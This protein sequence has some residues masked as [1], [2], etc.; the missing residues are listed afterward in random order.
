MDF[1]ASDQVKETIAK[2]GLKIDDVMDVVKTAEG[3][4]KKITNKD[5]KIIAKKV[6]NNVTVYADYNIEKGILKSHAN[7][8]S[9]YSHRMTLGK[10]V[11]ATEPS[12]WT[13]LHCNQQAFLGTAEMSYIGVSRNGPAVVCTKCGDVW[14]E[15]YLATKTLAAAEGLFE[16]KKA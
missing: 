13:C 14:V 8:N 4:N 9:A 5:G 12:P 1:K 11:N 2:R 6:I 3:A 15:E 16:K 7:V 10:I